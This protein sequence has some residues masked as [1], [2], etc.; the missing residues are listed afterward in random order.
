M[1]KNDETL[2]A[3]LLL[4]K[5][6]LITFEAEGS[7]ESWKKHIG[8]ASLLLGLRGQAQVRNWLGL[9]LFMQL[10]VSIL[11]SCMLHSLPVPE[12]VLELRGQLRNIIG[13]RTQMFKIAGTMIDFINTSSEL[14]AQKVS[15]TEAIPTLAHLVEEA[16][17]VSDSIP[18]KSRYETFYT[19]TES[20]MAYKGYYHRYRRTWSAR[21]W[22]VLRS[23]RLV[24][25][26]VIRRYILF[27]DGKN[28]S[29]LYSAL[30]ERAR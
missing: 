27:G 28:S 23:L 30:L 8:G 3:I 20:E 13:L 17:A 22:N 26:M 21:D 4:S 16:S 25:N 24:D 11:T 2:V 5:F 9:R 29:N 1:A 7:K 6:E 15:K 18:F 14:R 12:M 19:N 10:S